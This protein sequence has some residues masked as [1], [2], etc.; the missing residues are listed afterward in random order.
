MGQMIDAA[1]AKELLGCDDATLQGHIKSGALKFQR[2]DGKLLFDQD[3]VL[4]LSGDK[5]DENT[6]VL[7]G[8]SDNLHIDLGKVVDDSSETMVQ[9]KGETQHITFGEELEVVSLDDDK[10]PSGKTARPG[11]KASGG[12]GAKSPTSDLSF[13]DSNTAVVT[14]IEETSVGG[15]TGPIETGPV[16]PPPPRH[17]E[18]G[19]R[20]VRSSRRLPE[21]SSADEVGWPWVVMLALAFVVGLL[22]TAP[23][24]PMAMWPHETDKGPERDYAGNAVRGVDDTFWTSMAETLSFCDFSAEPNRAKWERNHGASSEYRDI[25]NLEPQAEWR[26]QKYIKAVGDLKGENEH[27][28]AFI[29]EKVSEDDTKAT[30]ASGKEYPISERVTKID[31]GSD[32]R[33]KVVE[34]WPGGN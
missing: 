4:R 15:T 34:V 16:G 8:E 3:D 7:T 32:I 31:G 6:I 18:S 5:E 9:A 30:S 23:L 26:H 25:S 20:S 11:P 13:T 29:I 22:V 10:K 28:K 21:L 12:K 24:Y 19:R 2:R 33:S 27:I 14:S 1:K 17:A